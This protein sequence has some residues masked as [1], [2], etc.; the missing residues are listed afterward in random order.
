M[1]I[2]SQSLHTRHV[3]AT[4]SHVFP[5]VTGDGISPFVMFK[6]FI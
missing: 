6:Y 3:Y 2:K 1:A 4:A 5:V